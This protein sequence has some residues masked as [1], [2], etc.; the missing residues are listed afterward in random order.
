MNKIGA[1]VMLAAVAAFVA[2]APTSKLKAPGIAE[3][4][5]L[6]SAENA[7]TY[8]ASYE[9]TFR[10]ALDALRLTD[11]ASAKFVKRSEGLIIFKKPDDAGTTTVKVRKADEETTRVEISAKHSRKYSLG[12]HDVETRD[13]FFAQ[14]EKLLG[15]DGTGGGRAEADAPE[16]SGEGSALTETAPNKARVLSD[17]K[18]QLLLEGEESFLEKLSYEDLV[19]LERRVESLSSVVAENNELTRRCSACYIDLARVYHDDGRYKRSAE[20]LGI[21]LSIDPESAIAHCNLGEIYKHLGLYKKG[22]R[23]LE[24]AIRLEPEFPDPHINLGIIYDDFLND[25][26]KALENYRKYVELGGADEQAL[27]WIREIEEASP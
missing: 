10:A 15:I 26:G 6:E 11:H 25:H 18:R 3:S 2:C 7:R 12:S 24:E 27:V 17:L 21:A 22:V 19:L 9:A 8:R 5:V 13:Q 23:E 1:A 20:A 16:R 14:L 4:P